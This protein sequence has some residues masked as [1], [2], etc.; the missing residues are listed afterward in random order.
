LQPTIKTFEKIKTKK[1]LGFQVSVSKTFNVSTQTMWE[2]LLSENGIT[3]WLG[4]INFEDFGIQ[5][6]F[7]TKEGIEGKLTVF[8]PDCHLRLKLKP[9]GFEKALTVEL[10]VTN[11]RGKAKVLFHN[12]GFYKIEQ[13]EQLRNRW[14]HVISKMATELT[15]S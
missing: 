10:R 12:T 15:K 4:E 3:I 14:K 1:D 2:F 9:I 8:V 11:S 5:K 13:V 6:Q 7:V